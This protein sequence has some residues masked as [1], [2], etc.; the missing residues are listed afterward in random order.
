MDDRTDLTDQQLDRQLA[1][2][3][4]ADDGRAAGL[5]GFARELREVYVTSPSE[6]TRARHLAAITELARSLDDDSVSVRTDP[7]APGRAR[8]RLLSRRKPML[9]SRP[10]ARAA[11]AAACA[12]S[13]VFATAG[14]AVAGVELPAPA[15]DAFEKLG[16]SLPNQA[17]GGGGG[18][19]ST[20]ERATDVRGVIDAT[21]PADRDCEFGQAVAG[22]A[23]GS[24]LPT[25]ARAACSRAEN[26]EARKNEAQ[27]RTGGQANA[28][29]GDSGGNSE[30]TAGRTFGEE[31]SQGAQGLDDATP[32]QRGEFGQ[33]TSEGAQ[34][35]GGDPPAPVAVPAPPAPVGGSETGQTQSDAGQAIGDEA[36]GGRQP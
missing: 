7:G 19:A 11:K 33:D 27:A 31:T 18:P 10:M 15:K 35:L 24:A 23:R 6:A 3:S 26:A 1:G 16:L 5:A 20:P 30:S 17:G 29:G 14:L 36:S 21:A 13:L 8:Q 9:T 4:P 2:I 12:A 28:G 25:E 22:A 34:E 32:E